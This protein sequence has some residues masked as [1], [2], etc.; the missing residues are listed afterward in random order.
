M[1]SESTPGLQRLAI[2]PPHPLPDKQAHELCSRTV[3]VQAMNPSTHEYATEAEVHTLV[4]RFEACELTR[5]EWNHRAHLTVAM[6]YLTHHRERRAIDLMIEGIQAFNQA[7]GIVESRRG[8][9]HETLTRF[10]LG[11]G[12]R[13][14]QSDAHLSP[15]DLVNRFL[16]APKDT[17]YR[18]YSDALLWSAE[19][20]S[21]WV[22][23]DLGS[24]DEVAA[25][26]FGTPTGP[27]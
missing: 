21:R 11:L 14:V 23:P 4:R 18:C 22:A 8:G 27:P 1:S 25:D 16:S 7:K 19:A 2:L 24:L 15:L 12:L 6:W 13:V 5:S 10:W 26:L 17:P 20:R 3:K 9:F